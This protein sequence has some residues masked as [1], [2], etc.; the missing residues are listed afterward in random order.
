[1]SQDYFLKIEGIEGESQDK[2]HKN[3][4]EIESIAFGVAQGGGMGYGGGGGVG[5]ATFQDISFTKKVDK[6]TLKISEACAS[7]KHIPTIVF[8]A[9]K[10]GQNPHE[11][12]L[13]TANDVIITGHS[14]SGSPSGEMFESVSFN[15]T[16]IKFKYNEQNEKGGNKGGNEFGWNIKQNASA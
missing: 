6:A 15:F 3:E 8:T 4:I 7:G 14:Y 11:F 12:L 10:A 5:K 16:K 2:T 13:V 9:R 1:M